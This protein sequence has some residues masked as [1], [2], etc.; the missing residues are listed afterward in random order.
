M[1]PIRPT[2]LCLA[3]AL[4]V[5]GGSGAVVAQ[6]PV[7]VVSIGAQSRQTAIPSDFLGLSF[8]IKTMLPDQYGG[9]FYSPTNL[10]LVTLFQNLGIRHV[11]MGGTTVE[12]PPETP[13]PGER[14]IDS[15]FAF[16]K[17]AGVQKVIYS[18]RL[19]ETNSALNY[20]ATNVPIARYIWDKYRSQL[21][22]FAIGNEP[23]RRAVFDHDAEITNFETYI[24]KWQRFA[25]V[26]TSEVPGA[27]FAGPD[28]GSGNAGWTT[29]FASRGKGA[30]PVALITAHFYVGGRGRDVPAERAIEDMLS[31]AWIGANERFHKAMAVPVLAQGLPFR[32]TEANDHYSGGVP[33]ASDTYAGALWAL[34]FLHW[35]AAHDAVGVNFHNTQW[36]VNDVIT[37]DPNGRLGINPKGYAFKAFTLGGH[38]KV[39]SL[40]LDKPA[41][42]NLTAYAVRDGNDHF[43]TLINKE[44][45]GSRDVTVNLPGGIIARAEIIRLSALNA[46]VTART[47]VTLGGAAIDAN[48]PWRGNWS[49][50]KLDPPGH[51]AL[52]L[53][54][55]SAAILR[56][57][58]K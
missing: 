32:L 15:L 17:T 23:D 49:D 29:R 20:A 7:V 47:G 26:L 31:P 24:I 45:A 39:E 6:L 4:L 51:C 43:L 48:G 5:S 19:L 3:A 12:F 50:V 18:L 28:G 21:D 11:R 57:T 1:P 10:Q 27:R 52:N 44:R 40:T 25:A 37:R 9:L 22:C 42:S 58:A 46:D 14:E 55:A 16:A 34:D 8:G 33:G 2:T 38:G 54:A 30:G 13:I 41:K 36:V 53:P 56:I 35:W